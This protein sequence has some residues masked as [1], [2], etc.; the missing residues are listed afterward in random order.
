[1]N[2]ANYVR[3]APVHYSVE[4]RCAKELPHHVLR[5]LC[6]AHLEEQKVRLWV[7]P[8]QD[9]VAH[10]RVISDRAVSLWVGMDWVL[11]LV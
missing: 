7:G 9:H 5:N 3:E 6:P 10:H 8:Q 1:M 2:C 4:A 11:G